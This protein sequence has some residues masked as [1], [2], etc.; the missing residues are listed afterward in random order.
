MI[1]RSIHRGKRKCRLER[2]SSRPSS[3]STPTCS[4]DALPAARSSRAYDPRDGRRASSGRTDCRRNGLV[5]DGRAID[6]A[7]VVQERLRQ[8]MQHK[9]AA[10]DGSRLNAN[11]VA[12]F[13]VRRWQSSRPCVHSRPCIS[14][15]WFSDL[16]PSATAPPAF[17]ARRRL[18]PR[19][20]RRCRRAPSSS[21]SRSGN[22]DSI[23]S[24]RTR[25]AASRIHTT[26]S[27]CRPLPPSRISPG[28]HK[29]P[30]PR[31]TPWVPGSGCSSLGVRA[32]DRLDPTAGL[33]IGESYRRMVTRFLW[34]WLPCKWFKALATVLG[35]Y[36]IS[37]APPRRRDELRAS[38]V[39]PRAY[40]RS[41][42]VAGRSCESSVSDGAASYGSEMAAR[43]AGSHDDASRQS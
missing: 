14:S 27:S 15:S 39:A 37:E 2:Y 3:A 17:S 35:S 31:L 38:C 42:R 26:A 19:E 28:T 36:R 5:K 16:C 18:S 13:D 1:A 25:P 9:L 4:T 34:A 30:E 32:L 21:P 22:T 23:P 20:A 40:R 6:A 7:M 33:Y 12:R 29:N 43:C 11:V 8:L 10:G 24:R 41:T